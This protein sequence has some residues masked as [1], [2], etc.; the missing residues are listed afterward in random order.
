MLKNL[1]NKIKKKLDAKLPFEILE[2]FEPLKQEYIDE[3]RALVGYVDENILKINLNEKSNAIIS[4]IFF[5]IF[6]FLFVF[7]G[8]DLKEGL[9]H[10]VAILV[11]SMLSI[12]CIYF[13]V[14][15]FIKQKVYI[16]LDRENGT[17]TFPYR[18][19][20]YKSYTLSFNEMEAVWKG[21]G[22]SSPDILLVIRSKKNKKIGFTSA[23]A[24]SHIRRGLIR[25]TLSFYVWY[26]DK[27][28][29]LPPGTAFDPYRQKDFERRKAERF[30]KPL[31]RSH[32][33]T[34]EATEEQQKEREQ[35]W[36]DEL[37]EFTREPHSVLYNP[38]I[39][40]NWVSARWLND[41]DSSVSNTYF[42]FE[43]EN[44]EIVYIKTD[45]NGR[46]RKPS[47][48]QKYTMTRMDIY[49]SWF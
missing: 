18:I 30:L 3:K 14:K 12:L 13:F 33:P 23:T 6:T 44:E 5:F 45:E 49:E 29:P 1:T 32:I 39:H 25:E 34:P 16:I 46:G 43:F 9:T 21:I 37:E 11:I 2:V 17:L 24:I 40:K 42:K 47:N 15:S 8:K 27:N 28:R 48:D 41:D 38:K 4:F 26:M 20:K 22:G 19:N 7:I 35:Y 31:Y 36:K 10:P